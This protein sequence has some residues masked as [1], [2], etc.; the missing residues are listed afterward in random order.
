[1]LQFTILN[2]IYIT[3]GIMVQMLKWRDNLR[4][5]GIYSFIFN[6]HEFLVVNGLVNMFLNL[7]FSILQNILRNNN[8]YFVYD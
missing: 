8:S 2:Y 6:K 3:Q 7:I 5:S 4:H 1:M